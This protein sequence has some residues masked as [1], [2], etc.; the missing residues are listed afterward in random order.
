MSDYGNGHGHDIA[1]DIKRSLRY[2]TRATVGLAL[3]LIAVSGY[4]LYALKAQNDR[5]TGALCALR[6]DLERRV[7]SSQ[8][9]LAQNP[10]G[11]PGITAASLQQSISGQQRSIV[12]LSG[13]H[14]PPAAP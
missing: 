4:G 9:F 13:L 7:A 3:V 11:I 12:A 8:E 14:C 6:Q 1:A 5:N 10:H 2:L